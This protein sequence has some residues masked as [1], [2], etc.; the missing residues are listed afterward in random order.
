MRI[1][2]LLLL[3]FALGGC[4]T[5]PKDAYIQD[6]KSTINT[7]WGPQTLQASMIATG[8]AAKNITVGE[9]PFCPHCHPNKA[10]SEKP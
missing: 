9:C 10:Q 3:A 5:W 7:P 8:T 4:R 1:I 2:L 6:P